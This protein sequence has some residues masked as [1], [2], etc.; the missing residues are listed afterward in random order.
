MK[1]KSLSRVWLCATPWTVAYQA[2]QSKGFSRQEHWSGLPFPSPGDLP[3]PGIEPM[4]PGIVDRR[5]TVW[6]T[7]RRHMGVYNNLPT[8]CRFN[9][10]DHIVKELVYLG[11]YCLCECN[12]P[13]IYIPSWIRI[14]IICALLEPSERKHKAI[15]YTFLNNCTFL[16]K[17]HAFGGRT[18]PKLCQS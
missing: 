16:L 6:A 4:S 17:K 1:V 14:K 2:P 7:R 11:L 9:I 5:F 12:I 3:D 15:S 10:S 8:Y 13:N 18:Y